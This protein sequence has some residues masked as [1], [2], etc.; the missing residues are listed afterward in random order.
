MTDESGKEER[1]DFL[2]GNQKAVS[3][4]L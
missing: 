4:G 2:E 1:L 3:R